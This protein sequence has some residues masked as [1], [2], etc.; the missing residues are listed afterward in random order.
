MF[1]KIWKTQKM[2]QSLEIKYVTNN[3][4]N[5]STQKLRRIIEIN[6]TPENLNK[7][8]EIKISKSNDGKKRLKSQVL[9]PCFDHK[10]IL[11]LDSIM[12]IGQ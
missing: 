8:L 10:L 6:Y 4:P 11:S 5:N 9:L 2:I 1:S 7:N 12:T 3:K